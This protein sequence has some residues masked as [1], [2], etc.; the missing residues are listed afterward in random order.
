MTS[1]PV[2]TD[3]SALPVTSYGSFTASMSVNVILAGGYTLP[4]GHWGFDLIYD[5]I[6]VDVYGNPTWDTVSKMYTSLDLATPPQKPSAS[7]NINSPAATEMIYCGLASKRD[8]FYQLKSTYT[9]N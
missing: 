7:L 1:T 5:V 6:Q 4:Q 9:H 8:K 2:S 3:C